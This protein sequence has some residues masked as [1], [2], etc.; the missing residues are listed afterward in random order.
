MFKIFP[1]QSIWRNNFRTY[2]TATLSHNIFKSQ[3]EF[4]QPLA[5]CPCVLSIIKKYHV[6]FIIIVLA[7]TILKID[8]LIRAGVF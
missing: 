7:V 5:G 4:D 8:Y 6:R 1:Q 2:E 3:A